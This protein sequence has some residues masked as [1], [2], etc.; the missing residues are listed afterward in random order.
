M[1]AKCRHCGRVR[2][3]HESYTLA[4]PTHFRDTGEQIYSKTH[5]YEPAPRRK[6]RK[7]VGK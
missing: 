4:C 2:G 7:A 3:E 5:C 6:A 1:S